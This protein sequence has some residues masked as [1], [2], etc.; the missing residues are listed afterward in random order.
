MAAKVPGNLPQPLSGKDYAVIAVIMV[1]IGVGLLV[2]FVLFAPRLVPA[3]ILEKF[4][5]IVL[6]VF[7]LVC[8]LVLFGVMKSYA[9]VTY[10]SGGGVVELGGPAAVALLVVVGGFWLVPH[11]D[12]FDLTIRP[13]APDKPLITSGKIRVELGNFANTQDISSNGEADFKGVPHKFR[14]ARVQVLPLVDG[15][16]QEYQTTLISGDAIDLNLVKPETLLRA[17]LVPAP[18]PGQRVK[19]LIENESGEQV[20]DSYGRF[21]AVVHKNLQD[22]VVVI[23][24]SNGRSVFNDNVSLTTEEVAIPTHK[25]DVRCG[26]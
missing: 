6:L 25:P 8:A 19:V 23:V 13:H 21:Q 16:K 2:L 4:F 3:D 9:R 18:A 12:T 11:T 20:P 7:G 24:C 14:G 10:K 5:Y 17:R 26:Q 1:V 22:S 15:Y